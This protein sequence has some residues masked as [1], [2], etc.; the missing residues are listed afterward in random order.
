MIKDEEL[1][2]KLLFVFREDYLAKLNILFEHVP[3]LLDQYLRLLP[4]HTNDLKQIIRAPFEKEELRRE[5]V[6]SQTDQGRSELTDELAGE[7][8][9][10]LARRSEGGR[11][12][13]SELQIVCRKLW[14]SRTPF[15]YL[16]MRAYRACLRNTCRRR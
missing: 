6:K 13:L 7:I 12:N 9:A 16:R 15:R 4:P 5:F 2:I 1:P 3:K 11:V 14:E 8:A 10:E